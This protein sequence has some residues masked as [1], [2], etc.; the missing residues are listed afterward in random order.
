[1]KENYGLIHAYYGKGVGKTTRAVGLAI[2]AAGAGKKVS[3][4]QFMKSGDSSEV[5]ILQS[6][7]N[8]DYFCPGKN[9][10]IYCHE[11]PTSDQKNHALQAF[12][13]SIN[14]SNKDLLICDEI[15]DAY[16]FG[17]LSL[18]NLMV[19]IDN[20]DK[21]LELILTGQ[22]VPETILEKADYVTEFICVKHPYDLGVEARKGIEY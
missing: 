2:R 5:S 12:E 1:M 18:N 21:N 10:F 4:V 15:L 13:H 20:K 9:E 19:L 3:F 17:S 7:E 8:I 6:L 16:L 22:C 11:K 14:C